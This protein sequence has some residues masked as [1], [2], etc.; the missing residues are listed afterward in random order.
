MMDYSRKIK[1]GAEQDKSQFD[2]LIKA[3]VKSNDSKQ[4]Q[5]L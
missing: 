2:S 5:Y 1:D 4:L 3:G